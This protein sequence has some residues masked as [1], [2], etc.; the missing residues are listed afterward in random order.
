MITEKLTKL[1]VARRQLDEAIRMFFE[2]RDTV[3][4]HSVASAAAQVLADLG[5]GRGFQGWTRNK[6]IIK[7]ERWKEW[8]VA[9]TRFEAFFKHADNDAQATCEFHPEITPL[10]IVESVH[11]LWVFTGKFTWPGLLFNIWFSLAHPELLLE[12][13][14]KRLITERSALLNFDIND[15]SVLADFLKMRDAI[16]AGMLDNILM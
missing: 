10:S 11:L 5:K 16:P 15:F 9:V 6:D 1:D 8:R 13:E 12:G 14:F 4:T 7:R 3:S 2:K